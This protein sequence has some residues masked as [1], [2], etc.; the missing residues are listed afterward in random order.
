[1]SL[2]LFRI[3]HTSACLHQANTFT[4]FKPCTPIILSPEKYSNKLFTFFLFL[5]LFFFTCFL[6]AK[7]FVNRLSP[8]RATTFFILQPYPC[9]KAQPLF[10]D[11]T[12][13]S[14]T[15]STF[16]K[17]NNF[18]STITYNIHGVVV[19]ALL[20][21]VSSF[22]TNLIKK[23]PPSVFFVQILNQNIKIEENSYFASLFI[24]ALSP[25]KIWIAPTKRKSQITNIHA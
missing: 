7:Y 21:H 14:K 18:A 17:I 2:L 10:C 19:R 24:Y 5:Q 15:N 1:M 20:E 11:F 8:A 16:L 9:I 22:S 4:I 13:F 6:F 3:L 12:D 25:V 23:L